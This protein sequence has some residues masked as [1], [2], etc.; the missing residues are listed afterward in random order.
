MTKQRNWVMAG[1]GVVVVAALVTANYRQREEAAPPVGIPAVSEAG[2][3]RVTAAPTAPPAEESNDPGTVNPAPPSAL[4][5]AGEMPAAGLSRMDR[6]PVYQVKVSKGDPLPKA[7]DA[8][9]FEHPA[10]VRAY[11]AAGRM[12]EVLAQL[13]CYCWC[14]RQG[15]A[16]LLDCFVTGHGAG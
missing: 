2:T 15:H 12:P 16:G 11:Q 4:N 13:P 1:L 5:Q 14:E 9:L 7:L 10:V 6:V 3:A 8:R